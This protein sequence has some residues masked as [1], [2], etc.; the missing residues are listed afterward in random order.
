MA[1]SRSI[2][3]EGLT[4]FPGSG[5]LKIKIAWTHIF[6]AMYSDKLDPIALLT[7]AFKLSEE[8]LADPNLPQA[9]Q[10]YGL[11]Q[12][13]ALLLWFNRDH[14]NAMRTAKSVCRKVRSPSPLARTSG[15]RHLPKLLWCHN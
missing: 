15:R 1:E 3:T 10:R 6:D 14:A 2:W 7:E 13:A 11:W 4:R 12:K 8:G 9:G 5:L